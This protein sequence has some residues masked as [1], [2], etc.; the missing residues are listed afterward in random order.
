MWCPAGVNGSVGVDTALGLGGGGSRPSCRQPGHQGAVM[1]HP[2]WVPV[3]ARSGATEGRAWNC[4]RRP[5]DYTQTHT[6]VLGSPAVITNDCN[7]EAYPNKLTL[8]VLQATRLESSRSRARGR[9]LLCSP[10]SAAAWKFLVH[11]HDIAS[12]PRG[13]ITFNL[14]HLP[15][16]RTLVTGCRPHPE[17]PGRSLNSNHFCKGLFSKYGH[18]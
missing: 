13:H 4:G 2:G 8:M 11:R 5:V 10:S 12:S 6:C 1:W 7:R 15:L 14:S 17:N 18:S 3:Y 16:I 9:P